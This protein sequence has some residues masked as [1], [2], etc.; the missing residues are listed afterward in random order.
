MSPVSGLLFG[1][2]RTDESISDCDNRSWNDG[3]SGGT[4]NRKVE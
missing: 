2:K 1:I 3:L 4:R